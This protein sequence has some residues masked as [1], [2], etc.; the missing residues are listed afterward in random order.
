MRKDAPLHL[1][2]LVVVG[3][4]VVADEVGDRGR[5]NRRL[6]DV[7]LRDQPRRQ[8][9][10]VAGALDAEP[11]AIDPRIAAQRGADA[12]QHVLPLVAV[13]IGEHGIRERLAVAGRAAVVHHQRRPAARG[14]DL[15]L[16]VERRSLLAVR[17]AVDVDD[18]RMLRRRPS[19]RAAW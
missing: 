7:G 10:A 9:T 15:I 17:P 4:V 18:Q 8:L 12:V 3:H 14:I 6:E 5:G 13:L 16:E 11:I 1:L 2:V 19:G